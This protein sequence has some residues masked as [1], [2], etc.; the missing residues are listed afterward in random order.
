MR[1]LI[2]DVTQIWTISKPLSHLND[3]FIYTCM[4]GI[5]KPP[6]FY[7]MC[8]MKSA[9]CSWPL[10]FST[11]RRRRHFSLDNKKCSPKDLNWPKV[12]QKVKSL[13]NIFF[14][15]SKSFWLQF[16]FYNRSWKMSSTSTLTPSTSIFTSVFV[17]PFLFYFYFSRINLYLPWNIE[18]RRDK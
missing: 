12:P 2:N 14:G 17:T 6:T 15:L 1:A 11:G 4:S 7:E 9:G 8:V 3:C 16:L 18:T 10:H 5:T 13:K